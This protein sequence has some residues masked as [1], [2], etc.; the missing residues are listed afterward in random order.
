MVPKKYIVRW[1]DSTQTEAGWQF[2]EDIVEPS[3]TEI[4]SVG[5]L[6]HETPEVLGMANSYDESNESVEGY[7]TI[8]VCC[9]TKRIEI[10]CK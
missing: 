6:I 9:I 5:Y 4:E 8:P 10:T 2:I 1:L 7:F 3:T